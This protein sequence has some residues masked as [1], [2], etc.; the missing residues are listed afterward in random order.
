MSLS[1]ADCLNPSTEGHMWI[2]HVGYGKLVI[3]TFKNT[4]DVLYP[5]EGEKL[6]VNVSKQEHTVNLLS[7]LGCDVINSDIGDD[8][9]V[10][11]DK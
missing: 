8:A 3:S 11:L 9:W 7:R 10:P 1:I 2:N 6:D 4:N 5:V